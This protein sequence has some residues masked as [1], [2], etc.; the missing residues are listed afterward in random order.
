M[1]S[2]NREA[3]VSQRDGLSAPANTNTPI[4]DSTYRY[5]K[6]IVM[7]MPPPAPSVQQLNPT[8]LTQGE[9]RWLV[10]VTGSAITL[11]TLLLAVVTLPELTN[12]LHPGEF[13]FLIHLTFGV[14]IVH[15]FAGGLATLLT[16][17]QSRAKERIR[18]V[19]TASLAIVS[20]LTVLSGTWLTYPGYRAKPPTG[21]DLRGYPQAYLEEHDLSYWHDLGM[22]WKEHVGWLTPF[23]ATAVAFIVFRY[24]DIVVR[25]ARVKAAVTAFFVM[26]FLASAIAAGL[27]AAINAV[28]PNEFL[29]K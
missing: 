4:A 19:T 27:G 1:Q 7:P 16:R 14:L 2:A 15:A 25:N 8:F 29:D 22:E 13:F 28:A 5:G 20:W 26:A 11:F 6:S 23:L 24:S 21:A 17:T 9:K 10:I 3:V 12:L 18:I